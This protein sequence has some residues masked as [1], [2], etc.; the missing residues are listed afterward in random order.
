MGYLRSC[1]LNVVDPVEV[2]IVDASKI[3][4]LA[5]ASDHLALVEQHSDPHTFE[6]WN[7]A[8]SV[9]ISEDTVNWS[10]ELFT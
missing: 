4:A 10:F 8:D 9:M 6:T 1:F 5:T 3:D 7:H 2:S